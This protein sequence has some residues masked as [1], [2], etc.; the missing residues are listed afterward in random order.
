MGFKIRIAREKG[1]AVS[2]RG[3]YHFFPQGDYDVPDQMSHNLA[4][5]AITQGVGVRIDDAKSGAPEQKRSRGRPRKQ[6]DSA[7]PSAST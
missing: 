6:K 5:R 3:S 1:W 2:P 4:Q 7:P